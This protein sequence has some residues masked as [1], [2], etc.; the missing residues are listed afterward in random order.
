RL[1]D[2]ASDPDTDLGPDE[3]TRR[4]LLSTWELSLDLLRGEDTPQASD[5]ARPLLRLLSAFGPAPIPY[6]ELLDPELLARS[7]LFGDPTPIPTQPQLQEALKGLAGLKLI[8]IEVTRR[9][10]ADARGVGPL[11]WITIHP[12][13]RAA[14]RAH[15]DFTAQA[16]RML[17]L[18]TAL[19][20]RVSSP[21][22]SANPAH[23][24]MWRA[25]APHSTAP[26][27]LLS[28]CEDSLG[29]AL[30]PSLVAAAT[31]A[32][33]G[34]AQYHNSLGMYGEAIAELQAVEAIRARLLGEDAPATIAT[35]LHLAWAL[36]DNGDLTE[37]D[38]LYQ[39][40]ARACERALEDD[41]PYLQSAR[42]GRARVLRER[43]RYEAAEA[44][45]SAALAMRRRDSQAGLRGVLRIRHDLA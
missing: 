35:R 32:A 39:E 21:L 38:R 16:S 3:R 13:V 30:N 27:V 28:A 6:Q 29:D 19:M 17:E 24:P 33:V 8:T 7:G 18:V 22:E 26:R 12:M 43:G 25:I 37:A 42:T 44:E 45:L 1:A 40:V 11:R 2:M 31:E 4:A 36:R 5:L 14:S 15:A 20:R 23:W 9:D 41:H 34:T 10:A